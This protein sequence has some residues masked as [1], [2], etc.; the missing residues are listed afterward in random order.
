MC[1]EAVWTCEAAYR[2]HNYTC[3]ASAWHPPCPLG[4]LCCSGQSARGAHL[5]TC[6]SWSH[7]APTPKPSSTS[8]RGS[9]L[10]ASLPLLSLA[11]PGPGLH[12]QGLIPPPF[13]STFHRACSTGEPW[14]DQWRAAFPSS[15]F[16]L[17]HPC[18]PSP[19]L[20][21]SHNSL[22]SCNLSVPAK[23]FG[24]F[25]SFIVRLG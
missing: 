11:E 22:C 6:S 25:L 3:K 9:C 13:S 7:P 21:S 17:L 19:C 20:L 14:A 18:R 10:P 1:L 5:G 24:N 8:P 12:L 15:S 23:G 4:P 16:H 2:Y